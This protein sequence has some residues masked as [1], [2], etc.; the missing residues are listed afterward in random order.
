MCSRHSSPT[1][2]P[3]AWTPVSDQLFDSPRKDRRSRWRDSVFLRMLGEPMG[4]LGIIL[5]A[6]IVLGALFAH[7]TGYSPIKLA[8]RDR[9]LEPSFSHLLCT[10][11]LG[12]D[13]FTR[14]LYG[15][16]IALGVAFVATSISFIVG[17][18]LGMI[19]GYGPRWLD[20]FLL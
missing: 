20:S 7:F 3:Q 2:S 5:V 11:H 15:A 17:L 9:F 1:S 19:A 12:R 6:L 18:V 13:L 4:A 14:V 16:R 10:D 8:M